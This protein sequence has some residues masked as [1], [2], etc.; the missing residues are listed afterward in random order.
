MNRT[1]FRC[2][3][4]MVT[5][6]LALLLWWPCVTAVPAQPTP[7][8]FAAPTAEANPAA[9]AAVEA[10]KK[11]LQRKASFPWYDPK[12]DELKRIDVSAKRDADDNQSNWQN[13]STPAAPTTS[14]F[15]EVLAEVVRMVIYLLIAVFVAGLIVFLIRAFLNRENRQVSVSKTLEADELEGEIARVEQLPFQV[16]AP[17]GDLLSEAERCYQA[18]D[19]DRAIIYLFSYQLVKLDQHQVIRLA[20]GKTN[21]QYVRET[22][23]RPEIANILRNTMLAF[24]DVFFGHHPLDRERF[25]ACWHELSSFQQ[26]LGKDVGV[27]V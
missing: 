27:P 18:G 13:N 12:T 1:L 14:A 21:R 9:D 24:E 6:W 22:R 11:S 2:W 17:R 16:A 3:S 20:R 4:G 10:G 7:L 19:Y 25:E 5:S 8:Q 15:W 23:S 26:A